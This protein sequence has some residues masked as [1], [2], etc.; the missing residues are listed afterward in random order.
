MS[1]F[2]LRDVRLVPLRGDAAPPAAV[3]VRVVRRTGGRGRPRSVA[4]GRQLSKR[5][6]AD[7][8]WLMPGLWDQHVHLGQWTLATLRLD[9]TGTR[10]VEDALARVAIRIAEGPDVP[11]VGWG[12]RSASWARQ[13]T[14]EELD[15]V[16]GVR[17]VVLISGDGHHAWVNSVALRGLG[18]PER[19]GVVSE[20]EWFRVYPRLAEV[21]GSD[22]TSPDAYLHTMQQAAAKGVTGVVDLEFDQSAN[23]LARARGRRRRAAARPRRCV[24]RHAR[25][26]PRSGRRHR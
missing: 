13:P 19:N 10:S 1:D 16:T 21:V 12:H 9:L 20:T 25:R 3:D 18:L 4:L 11:I 8:R 15:Q 5:C 23:G 6:A 22:G 26:L 17:P 2:V 14:V 24:R 7:G